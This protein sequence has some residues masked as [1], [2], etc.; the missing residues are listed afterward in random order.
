VVISAMNGGV[1]Q[2]IILAKAAGGGMPIFHR[3]AGGTGG[4]FRSGMLVLLTFRQAQ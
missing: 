2:I 3:N 1:N 4:G